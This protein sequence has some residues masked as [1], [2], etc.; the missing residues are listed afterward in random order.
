MQNAEKDFG[1]A[2]LE[3]RK[4]G[5][6]SQEALAEKLNVTRQTVSSWERNKSVPDLSTL[7][8][9]CMVLGVSV[10]M[11]IQ[12]TVMKFTGG[13]E[14]SHDYSYKHSKYDQAIGLGYAVSLFVAPILC[15]L[16]YVFNPLY[17]ESS[18]SIVLLVV[19]GVLTFLALGLLI[20]M[21]ITLLRK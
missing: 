17:F 3:L 1:S 2:L 15:M 8:R 19:S 12:G 4:E 16:I 14:M 11:F 20:Q 21:T 13:D 6:M 10:D 18:K 5:N 7:S 9:L